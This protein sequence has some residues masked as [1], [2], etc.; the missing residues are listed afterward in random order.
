MG[1]TKLYISIVI[2]QFQCEIF[3]IVLLLVIHMKHF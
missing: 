3:H 2:T 1:K